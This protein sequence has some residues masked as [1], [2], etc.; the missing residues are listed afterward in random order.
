MT[1]KAKAPAVR[2]R[3]LCGFVWMGNQIE[4]GQCVS[5]AEPVAAALVR[6]GRVELLAPSA[7]A[8]NSRAGAKSPR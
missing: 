3:S 6:A 5:L 4:R 7:D 1:R 8:N 2:V